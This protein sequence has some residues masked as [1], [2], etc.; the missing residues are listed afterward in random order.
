[1]AKEI[2]DELKERSGVIGAGNRRVDFKR[3]EPQVAAVISKMVEDTA[4]TTRD[5]NGQKQA[6]PPSDSFLETVSERTTNNINE[7]NSIK[8]LLPD[9]ELARQI[10][11]SSIL[12]PNDLY[13]TEINFTHEDTGL[14]SGLVQAMLSEVQGHFESSYK[15]KK[16]LNPI[17]S[18]SLFNTGSYPLLILPENSIDRAINS[19]QRVSAES[20]SE[21]FDSKGMP[22]PIGVLGKPTVTYSNG[23]PEIKK[24]EGVSLESLSRVSGAPDT[25]F[26][27]NDQLSIGI[28][29]N[30]SVLKMPFLVDRMTQD[31]VQDVYSMRGISMESRKDKGKMSPGELERS[32][33]QKRRY[34]FV[35]ILPIYPEDDDE[36]IGNPLVMRLPSE[37]VIP[38][39]L[40]SNPEDHV[41]YFVLLDGMGNPLSKALESDY[42]N[43]LQRNLR[44]NKELGPR[45]MD[46]AMQGTQGRDNRATPQ[47]IEQ[48]VNAY[49]DMVEAEL[50]SSLSNG[51]YGDSVEV[52]RPQEVY[53]IMLARAAANMQTRMLYV[54]ASLMTYFAFDYNSFGVGQSLLDKSKLLG[55]LR[56]V[57]M[58]ANTMAQVRNSVGR[59]RLNIQLDPRDPDPTRTVEFLL[60]EYTRTSKA[61]FPLGESNPNNLVDF[62]QKAGISLQVT[63]NQA[64]PET[65][66]DVEDNSKDIRGVDTELEDNIRRRHT[67]ALGLSPE[68]VDMSTEVDFATSVV[69]SNLLLSKRVLAYQEV[70]TALLAEFICKYTRHSG[71][72][73]KALR[74]AVDEH[75]DKLGTADKQKDQDEII[76]R[77]LSSLQV[78]LPAPD[79]SSLENQLEAYEIYERALEMALDAYFSTEF[80]TMNNM[81]EL[82]DSAEETRFAL[83][84]YFL[85]QWLRNNNMLPELSILTDLDEDGKGFD[86]MKTH[87]EHI[88]AVGKVLQEYMEK[89]T[90]LKGERERR[91][92]K[93][94]EEERRKEEEAEARRRIED[95]RRRGEEP[96]EDDLALVGQNTSTD[97]EETELDEEETFSDEPEETAL[98]DEEEPLETEEETEAEE[99]PEEEEVPEE[100]ESDNIPGFFNF[101]EENNSNS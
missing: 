22:K 18:D 62:L 97:E 42:Y 67:M 39:H 31:R 48:M 88:E 46:R 41:G 76:E 84:A 21:E 80:L 45:L 82:M 85:R 65:S 52:S 43:E 56:A 44:T 64:Y 57:L 29:D 70:F 92:Q 89:M 61:G 7:A 36:N 59:E 100:E 38:V 23:K 51:I 33:Y 73:M 50:M 86:L 11:V 54:P 9:I 95:A 8:E 98:I 34:S 90:K 78:T 68:V 81:E 60:H 6:R 74:K 96:S 2:N 40:P 79:N 5:R 35:P 93:I 66:M 13:R 71:T 1:M 30:P 3:M 32:V 28:T 101:D 25:G 14:D 83:K 49:T 99:E 72:L 15:I 12:S 24:E 75:K 16:I 26:Y 47:E 20:Y 87:G 94:E 55:S 91:R 19:S 37:S 27:K 53:R 10:L 4:G 63:G 17:L 69:S 77:F 58:F